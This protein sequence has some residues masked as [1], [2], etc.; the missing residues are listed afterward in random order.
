[1][2]RGTSL[3]R[4]NGVSVRPISSL[5]QNG[6]PTRFHDPFTTMATYVYETIPANSQ[7]QPRR[8]EVRQK[9]SDPPLKTDPQT[10]EPVRRIITGGSGLVT[11]GASILSMKTR[12]R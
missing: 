7:E 11:H 9:M 10:G 6:F 8:F 12:G 5:K 4:R 2:G 1:M 3:S